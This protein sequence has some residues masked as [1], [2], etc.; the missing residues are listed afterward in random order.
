MLQIPGKMSAGD[1]KDFWR[2]WKRRM[3]FHADTDGGKK[4]SEDM[5]SYALTCKRI[6]CITTSISIYLELNFTADKTG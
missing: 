5:H 3:R 2:I 4:V 1:A 6:W